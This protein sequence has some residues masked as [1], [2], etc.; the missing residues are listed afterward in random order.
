[1]RK[2]LYIIILCVLSIHLLSIDSRAEQQYRVKKGDTLYKIATSYGVSV[3]QIKQANGFKGSI[4]N[5]GDLIVVPVKTSVKTTTNNNSARKKEVV[6]KS[7]KAVD[8][9]V[10][11][12][13]KKGDTLYRISKIYGVTV[14]DVRK[15]NN[16][17]G[18]ALK[19]GQKLKVRETIKANDE[20]PVIIEEPVD[21][22]EVAE[23]ANEVNQEASSLE[24]G[25]KPLTDVSP[26]DQATTSV[27][28]ESN[29]FSRI[30][31]TAT[32][33]LGVPYRFGGTTLKGIDCS[34]YVQMVYSYFS[35]ELPRTAREQFKAGVRVSSKKE[36]EIGDLIFF[37][38]YAK[39][40]S[41]VGIYIGGGKMI[42]ASSRNKKVTVSSINEPYYVKRYIGAVR[43][44]DTPYLSPTQDFTPVSSN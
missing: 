2:I 16:L 20:V 8:K 42:H 9:V 15:L 33:Y 12:K 14:S 18:S 3:K 25:A 24:E 21:Q 6:N 37:R 17:S 4:I 22:G 41:H 38:T 19:I 31:D 32:D 27:A 23:V 5:P 28:S 26:A 35:I 11:H 40:P 34:A 30:V 39:F 13:V 7:D 44:P 1:M 29:W 36:L 10:T 43:L